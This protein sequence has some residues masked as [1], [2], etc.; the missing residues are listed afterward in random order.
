MPR[1]AL[2]ALLVTLLV[3]VLGVTQGARAD[4]APV[5]RAPA[6]ASAQLSTGVPGCDPEQRHDQDGRQG[7]P[8]R[9]TSAHELLAP[10]AHEHGHA[11]V[12]VLDGAVPPAPAGRGPPPNDPPSPV[13]LSVL[14]V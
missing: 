6:A 11:A 7:V 4:S 14:R 8:S 9:G 3:A 12:T 10:L 5:E 13:E 1:L 2:P